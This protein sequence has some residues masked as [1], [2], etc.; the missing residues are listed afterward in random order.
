MGAVADRFAM[1][2]GV[3]QRGQTE[4]GESKFCPHLKQ[5]M[6]TSIH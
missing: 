2:D 5:N 3:L 6:L 4:D 1:P